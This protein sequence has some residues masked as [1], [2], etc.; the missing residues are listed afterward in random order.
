[1]IPEFMETI[2]FSVELSGEKHS[3]HL[4]PGVCI[5]YDEA[6]ER[7]KRLR[8]LSLKEIEVDM[9]SAANNILM[10]DGCGLFRGRQITPFEHLSRFQ[11]EYVD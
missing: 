9:F 7:V 3:S 5:W 4:S 6:L 2:G 1:M 11:K 10:N 8:E